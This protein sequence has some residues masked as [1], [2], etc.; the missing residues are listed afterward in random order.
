MAIM[1]ELN[2]VVSNVTGLM[3]LV[4]ALVDFIRG[5]NWQD[6]NIRAIVPGSDYN[7]LS[8]YLVLAMSIV[9]YCGVTSRLL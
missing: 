8:T 9:L 4:V 7:W 2:L 6:R 3:H 1:A 5:G